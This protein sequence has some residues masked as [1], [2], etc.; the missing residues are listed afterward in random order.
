MKYLRGD[1]I[2][3]SLTAN[4][5]ITGTETIKAYMGNGK[6]FYSQPVISDS[7]ITLLPELTETFLG[8]YEIHIK[9]ETPAQGNKSGTVFT[10]EVI[11]LYFEKD[12]T[13]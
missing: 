8:Y 13:N 11:E 4:L 6:D 7:T 3:I 10:I 5:S 1:T 9:R 2:T 12:I